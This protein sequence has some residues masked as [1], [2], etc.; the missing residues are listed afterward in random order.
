[1]KSSQTR[2]KCVLTSGS[3]GEPE[4]IRRV[5]PCALATSS[6]RSGGSSSPLAE[7]ASCSGHE[8]QET[9]L[10]GWVQEASEAGAWSRLLPY[11]TTLPCVD[12]GG[13]TGRRFKSP[14]QTRTIQAAPLLREEDRHDPPTFTPTLR[15]TGGNHLGQNCSRLFPKSDGVSDGFLLPFQIHSTLFH[16]LCAPASRSPWTPPMGSYV[17]CLPV[18]FGHHWEMGGW[19]ERDQGICF[20]RMPSFWVPEG[21]LVSSLSQ[22]PSLLS[23]GPLHRILLWGSSNCSLLLL[24]LSCGFPTPWYAFVNSL[25]NSSQFTQSEGAICFL[26]GP[27]MMQMACLTG[28]IEGESK[29]SL[30][31]QA[32]VGQPADSWRLLQTPGMKPGTWTLRRHGRCLSVFAAPILGQGLSFSRGP[33]KKRFPPFLQFRNTFLCRK[34]PLLK[35]WCP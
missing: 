30:L 34:G 4:G 11:L 3:H 32:E 22:K 8:G 29:D 21:Y 20:P 28:P 12:A 16:L 17:L 9:G 6:G 35:W 25:L 7:A 5:W 10:A 33:S 18:A 13:K 31:L 24:L 15:S 19:E 14:R 23:R 1:M 26:P 27:G 2:G